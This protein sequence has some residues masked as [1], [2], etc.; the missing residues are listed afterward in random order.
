MSPMTETGCEPGS[1]LPPPQAA[2]HSAREVLLVCRDASWARAVRSACQNDH[3]TATDARG[4]LRGLAGLAPPYSHLLLQSCCDD[5]LLDALFLLSSE[6]AGSD[7]ELILLGDRPAPGHQLT[8]IRSASPRS[9]REALMTGPRS[10][11]STMADLPLDDLRAALDGGRISARYQPIVRIRDRAPIALEVL[12]RLDHPDK[13][14][15]LPDRFVP[16]IEDAGL[17]DRLTE[18][19]TARAFAEL[20]TPALRDRDL[21]VTLNFPLDVILKPEALAR[22]DA[23]RAAAGIPAHRVAIELTESMPVRDFDSLRLVLNSIRAMGYR[24]A[25]DD[26]SPTVSGLNQLLTLPFTTL[27]LDKGLITRAADDAATLAFVRETTSRA[28]AG[29]MS[30]VAEGIE[31]VALWDLVAGLG[32]D[33]AQ[34]YLLARPLPAA[35]VAIWLD[36]WPNGAIPA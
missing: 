17:A 4:A 6:A 15:V 11:R 21:I 23:Q 16:R 8:T 20:S 24:A 12:A 35:A 2:A 9:V 19:I 33:G 28:Q 30:V 25:I 34:G 27:K 32:V 3:V 14:V 13:G 29:G 5:G 26:V 1:D 31:T 7:T 22:L 18:V 36:D 10:T